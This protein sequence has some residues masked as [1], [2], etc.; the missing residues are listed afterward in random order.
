[1]R[2]V[3][4]RGKPAAQS[5][6]NATATAAPKPSASKA[7]S[8]AAAALALK[9]SANVP[10]PPPPGRAYPAISDAGDYEARSLLYPLTPAEKEDKAQ[11]MLAL[12]MDEVRKFASKGASAASPKTPVKAPAK[13]PP[14]PQSFVITDY[15]LRAFDLDFSSSPTLVLTAKVPAPSAKAA[16]G[17]EFDYFVTVVARLDP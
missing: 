5:G 16:S 12:A 9:A 3:L 17:S 14:R 4:H 1:D 7:A 13:A 10:T 8:P 11:P 15:D 6:S 2:P